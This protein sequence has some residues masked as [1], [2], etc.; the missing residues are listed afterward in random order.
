MKQI[1][2]EVQALDFVEEAEKRKQKLQDEFPRAS[3]RS[4]N[5]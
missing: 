2:K 5:I 1:H 3:M 4:G